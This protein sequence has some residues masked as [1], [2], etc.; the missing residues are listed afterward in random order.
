MILLEGPEAVAAKAEAVK[1][2][3]TDANGALWYIAQGAP[4]AR[5]R[6]DNAHQVFRD[7]LQ[8]FIE[9]ARA[10]IGSP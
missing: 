4:E 1:Q 6:F 5:S 3:A 2:A 8:S 10:T 9:T 7:R